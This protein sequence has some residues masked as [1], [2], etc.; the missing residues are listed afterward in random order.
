M[1]RHMPDG[2]P[3]RVR[4]EPDERRDQILACA[5]ELFSRRPYAS[6][7]NTDIAT[8]AGVS[9]G[10]L[11]HYFG[12]K[13]ELYLAAVREML[14]VPPIPTPAFP[15]GVTMEERVSQSIDAWLTLL[16]R[17]RETWI[18]ALD[19]TSS[20]GDDDLE[21][22]LEEARDGAVDHM[23][24]VVGLAAH[25]RT[26]PQIRA[27]FRC[28]SALAENVSREWLK[29]ARLPRAQAH[30]LLK[31]VLLNLIDRVLPELIDRGRQAPEPAAT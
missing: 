22:I 25:S 10:L 14:R 3:R 26:H 27:A 5:R 4:K 7:S 19:L 11:N 29:H 17:N 21:H 24:Q 23:T 1:S 9:R 30:L 15:D 12:T 31:E 13:R 18:A 2:A 16:E 8:A 6:V 28:Y 20:G